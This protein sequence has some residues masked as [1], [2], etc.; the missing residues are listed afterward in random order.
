MTISARTLF[1]IALLALALRPTTGEAQTTPLLSP[2]KADPKPP[3]CDAVRGD[4]A[5]GWRAQTRAEVMAQH[6]MVTTSQPLASQAGLQMLMKGGNAIDAAVAA[7]AVLNVVEPM[8]T[9]LAGDLFAII[10]IAKENKL[11][12]L[13][14][15]G[16]APTGA[17]LEHLN[18]L[19]YRA[20]PANFGPGSGMPTY[21][22]LPVTV[23]GS[24]W[25]W[26]EVLKRFGK[27]GFKEALAPAIDY[28]EN[29]FP[30]SQRIANDWKLPNALPLQGC[31]T[32]LDPDSVK[33]WY[34]DGKQPVAGQ[35]FRNPDLAKTLRLLQRHG[36]D[37][38]YKGEIAKA[39]V[40]KST[41]LGGTLTLED[42]ASYKGEW[43]EA[44]AS[45]YHGFN[46]NELPPPS[47]AWGTN[48][49]LNILEA[50][51]PKWAQGQTLASLGP[52]NPKYWHFLVEA[53][54]LAYADLFRYNAD[55]NFVK[56]PLAMLLSKAHAE[57]LCGKVDPDHASPTGLASTASANG[58][59]I[60]L[61]TAD[62]EGNMV[63]WVNSN[64][65]GFGSG[66]TV[67]GYGFILHNRGALFTLDPK[68]PNLIAPHKRPFNTLSAG[69]VMRDNKPLMSILLMGGDMQAQ[70]HAQTLV[71][72]LD[73][74]ANLQA[75]TDMA[76]FHHAQ[77]QNRLELESNLF[78]LV[79]KDLAAMGHNVVSING[80][81]VGGFQSILFTPLAEGASRLHGFYRA[82][83][84]HRKDGEA[85]GW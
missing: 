28:A 29:G 72:I 3:A 74:G 20:D 53:K 33:T 63:S 58:D 27:M 43:V 54:K 78:D 73:L 14:A 39:I 49:M 46:L 82:G 9:G 60:V 64:Y 21:G 44:A 70:G 50:C 37:A 30:V 61:S 65:A 85:V 71:S 62:A 83:S 68:S 10:Y 52:R 38:F 17:T 1:C 56:V 25:G 8:N 23:P 55:P 19:G 26:E 36:R 48:V 47:Q 42:L 51:T 5:D 81:P 15:S 67:P 79:G 13:N 75:A 16:M 2:C 59:T 31:C 76:R 80:A 18:A 6:G 77:V 41:S 66:L 40:A 35:I 57:E 32:A 7:A 22:I 24:A 45:D 34:I 69:F 12:T 84:D 4:R 11:Y